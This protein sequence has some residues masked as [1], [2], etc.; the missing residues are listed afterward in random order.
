MGQTPLLRRYLAVVLS[1]LVAGTV[2]PVCVAQTG[3]IEFES[4]VYPTRVAQSVSDV[5]EV[6]APRVQTAGGTPV[7]GPQGVCQITFA[8]S[9]SRSHEWTFL[10]D[11]RGFTAS[12]V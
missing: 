7:E 9:R 5:K 3:S 6:A 10:R 1:T 2:V 11:V 8:E 4:D 12:A